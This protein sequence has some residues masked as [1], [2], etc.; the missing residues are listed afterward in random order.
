MKYMTFNSSCPY[1]G[2]ANL[3]E[4]HGIDTEDH[5]IALDM[6]LPYFLRYDRDTKCYQ[7]GASLQ[8]AEWFDLYL[9]PRG[10]CYVEKAYDKH[11]LVQELKPMSM[12]G[13]Q[14][15]AQSKHAV[16][17]LE[18]ADGRLFFLNNKWKESEE[19]KRLGLTKEELLDRL[20]DVVVVGSLERCQPGQVDIAPYLRESLDTWEQL[21]AEMQEYI[22]CEQSPES[23]R[24]SMN[25]LFRPLLLDGLTM[26]QLAQNNFQTQLLSELQRIYLTALRRNQSITLADTLDPALIDCAIAGMKSAV[27]DR[28]LSGRVPAEEVQKRADAMGISKRTLDIAKKNLGIISE[29]VGDQWFWKLPE[30]GCKD[31]EF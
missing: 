19:P 17:Y 10:F 30:E 24:E 29:K 23:L 9:K 25:R 13:L 2:L 16:I 18:Q 12:M 7:A 27:Q 15:T 1:A 5:Q 20:P 28:M 3:L 6:G 26:M 11:Q 8:S 4:L 14:V 21:R 31:V 22:A